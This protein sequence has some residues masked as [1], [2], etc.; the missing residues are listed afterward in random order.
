MEYFTSLG[1]TFRKSKHIHFLLLYNDVTGSPQYISHVK[2]TE[3]SKF[4]IIW[5]F[6]NEFKKWKMAYFISL[7]RTLRKL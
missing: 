4:P 1:R 7:G 2:L 3:P 6:E 5:P